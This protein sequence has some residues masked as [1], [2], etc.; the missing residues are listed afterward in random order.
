MGWTR[1]VSNRIAKRLTMEGSPYTAGQISHG[2]EIFLLNLINAAVLLLAAW[3]LGIF[4]ETLCFAFILFLHRVITGG[5]H[6]KNPWTCLIAGLLIMLGGGYLVKH[7]P[8]LPPAAAYALI[9]LS[10]GTAFV[11]YYRHAPAAHS[12]VNYQPSVRQ[13]SRKIAF[14]LLGCACFLSLVLVEFSYRLAITYTLAV[15]LQSLLLHP[16][17]FRLVA[18]L[19]KTFSKGW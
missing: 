13:T 9:L 2:I 8:L 15:F 10:F 17:A 19:E 5:V 18:R 4:P 14:S 3:L 1:K 16:V 7:V 11:I 12:Y 6:L